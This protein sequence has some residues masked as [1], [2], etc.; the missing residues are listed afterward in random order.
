MNDGEYYTSISNVTQLID[1]I[2][3]GG[4]KD[5]DEI[6]VSTRNDCFNLKVVK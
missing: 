4:L 6:V 5:G 2:L 3:N 1:V